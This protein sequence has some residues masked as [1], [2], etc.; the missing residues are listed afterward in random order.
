M[1]AVIYQKFRTTDVL[2]TVGQAKP[3]IKADQVLIK[4]KAFSINPMD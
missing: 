4:V 3:T 2:Q 1:K